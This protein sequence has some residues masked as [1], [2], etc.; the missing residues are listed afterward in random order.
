MPHL[1]VVHTITRPAEAKVPWQGRVGR[2]DANLV[3]ETTR[4]LS[5]PLF[6]ICGLPGMVEDMAQLLYRGLGIPAEDIR[7]ERFMGY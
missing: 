5:E 1:R 3:Q 6:Y 7:V 4:D 2:I